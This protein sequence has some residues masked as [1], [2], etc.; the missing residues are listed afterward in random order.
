MP[1]LALTFAAPLALVACLFLSGCS[2]DKD[3]I[4]NDE[5]DCGGSLICAQTGFCGGTDCT[6]ICSDPCD[7]DE[8]CSGSE[9]CLDEPGTGRGYC[10]FFEEPDTRD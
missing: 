9:R 5:T 2:S 4:C 6:G 8:D 7:T 3:S 10:R 1:K